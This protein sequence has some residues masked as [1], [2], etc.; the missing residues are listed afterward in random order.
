MTFATYKDTPGRQ[1]ASVL[2]LDL[3]FCSRSYGVSPCTADLALYNDLNYSQQFDVVTAG[4][5][6]WAYPA[7]SITAN[8][9]TAPDGTLTADEFER[10]VITSQEWRIYQDRNS[11]FGSDS[12][13]PSNTIICNSWHVKPKP[14]AA[15]ERYVELNYAS[16]ST[17]TLYAI[18]DIIDG[19]LVDGGDY[20]NTDFI[21]AG[22]H[23]AR[24]TTEEGW[25]RIWII[26]D[27]G[28]APGTEQISLRF[29]KSPFQ[30]TARR[31]AR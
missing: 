1:A 11:V 21:K 15:G 13:M 23:P 5:A 26:Y 9:A 16:S 17:E 29:T 4:N 3:D 18:F 19:Y 2:E 28:V 25:F 14:G 6:G 20:V 10:T 8:A 22:I 12:P 7:S 24:N 30:V 27:S 31:R